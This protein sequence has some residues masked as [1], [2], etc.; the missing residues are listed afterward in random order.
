MNDDTL[1]RFAIT[2]VQLGGKAWVNP[3]CA[4]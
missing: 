1:D 2:P 3:S 4:Q